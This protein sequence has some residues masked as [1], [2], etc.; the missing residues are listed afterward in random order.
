M[1]NKFPKQGTPSK[2]V[3][4]PTKKEFNK[5]G[6]MLGQMYKKKSGRGS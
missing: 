3:A 4:I 5:G 2:K 6:G 1:P